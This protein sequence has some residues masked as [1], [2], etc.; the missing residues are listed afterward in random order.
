MK[1][2]VAESA[3]AVACVVADLVERF[4]TSS[5]SSALGLATGRTM[6]PVFAELVRRHREQGLS[7]AGVEAY[8][9]DEYL[10]LDRCDPRAYRS[11]VYERLARHIDIEL[12][13]LHGP[14]PHASDLEVECARYE[15]QVRAAPIGLQLLGIGANGHI[16]FN[17]PGSPLDS[18]TRV[19][20]LSEQTRTDNAQCFPNGQ[21]PQRAITQGIA[22]IG[23]AGELLLAA[24]GHRKAD[25]VARAI[26]GPVTSEVPA[27]AIQRH[28]KATVVL[29]PAAAMRLQT[30][31]GRIQ[32]CMPSN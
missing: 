20:A 13:A 26:S 8:L 1:V 7:F 29:D 3:G 31:V 12:G 22:T 16:A 15:Q 27:S 32:A 23:A 18:L 30:R 19:V 21:S 10:G 14:D 25:A 5:P 6:E 11:V 28:P 17:E 24:T 2:V 9:L 4:V